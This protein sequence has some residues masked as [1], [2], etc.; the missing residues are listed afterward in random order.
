MTQATQQ[1]TS[2]HTV[3]ALAGTLLEVCSCGVLCP[4]F[5]G[6]DP[7]GGECL[8]VIAYHL[9]RGQIQGVDVSGLSIV[10]VV[11]LPGNVFDGSWRVVV[12]SD[13]SASDEQHESLLA[14]FAGDL[15]GPLADLAGLVDEVVAVERVPITHDVEGARGVLRVE[16]A[17]EAQIAPINAAPDGSPTT[18]HNSAFSTVAGAPAY[19]GKA[20]KY[21]VNL[22]QHGMV[23]SFQG[24]NAIQT[25]WNMQ[26]SA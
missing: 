16:G 12:Y 13:A 3:Y 7:D 8:G 10:N 1:Q 19:V 23:W 18:L 25:A 5:I 17:L 6:E 24:H 20:A 4:C 2:R 14:A 22:P 9:E 21:E 11:Q 26:H 15:G